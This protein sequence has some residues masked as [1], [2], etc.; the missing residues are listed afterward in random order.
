MRREPKPPTPM[1]VSLVRFAPG[2]H[3]A[4]RS[5]ALGQTL[6]ITQGIALIG[7][8]DGTIIEAHPSDTIYTPPGEEHWHGATPEDF[9][10]HLTM[11]DNAD[12]PAATTI[13]REHLTA[14]QYHRP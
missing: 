10:E 14:Q 12:E 13:W 2:A 11:L 8:R 5:H 1:T 7:T 4:W 6:H 3:T 9:M